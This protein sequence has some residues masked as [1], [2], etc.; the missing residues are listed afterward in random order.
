MFLIFSFIFF[1]QLNNNLLTC[2]IR[3]FVAFLLF[4]I[5]F[6]FDYYFIFPFSFISFYN[7][8]DSTH[9]SKLT[10]QKWC[11]WIIVFS[12][13]IVLFSLYFITDILICIIFQS[14]GSFALL[15]VYVF[16]FLC[17]SFSE[18]ICFLSF[19]CIFFSETNIG[20]NIK[21]MSTGQPWRESQGCTYATCLSPM[22]NQLLFHNQHVFFW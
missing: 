7:F 1:S 5:T 3:I 18:F 17:I 12:C 9:F 11:W 6:W 2:F 8:Y 15:L 16:L 22:S 19:L 20:R 13:L 21:E 4:L 10:E 14:M